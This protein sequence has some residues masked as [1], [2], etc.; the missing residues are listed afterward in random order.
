MLLIKLGGS[1][2]T[3]K[4]IY[5]NFREDTLRRIV[6]ALPREDMVI[7][8]GGGSFGHV[9]AHKYRIIDGFEEH[10]RMG[11]ARIGLDMME[12]NSLVLSI[13]HENDIPGISVPPHAFHIFGEDID[14]SLFDAYLS[15]GFVPVTYGDIILDR[16]QGINICS[17]DYLMLHLAE[18]FRPEKTIFLTDVDGIYDRNPQEDG[19]EL[20]P[21]LDRGCSPGTGVN[22]KDVTG[23]MEY[24][25][26]IMREIAKHSKVYVLNGFY[27]E[28]IRKVLNDEDFI[29]TVVK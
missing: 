9:L 5:K 22:V 17:G 4:N 19:A 18:K 8:H 24:K 20:L 14:L 2:I 3:D 27:P 21:V 28:R 16:E 6:K 11:F 29:G 25:I 13:L 12:L 26:R 7:V 23:G 15:L 1:V 10:K